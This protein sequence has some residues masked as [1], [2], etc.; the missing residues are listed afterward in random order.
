MLRETLLV[1]MA[2]AV[3]V[4]ATNVDK[5][6]GVE[7]DNTKNVEVSGCKNPPCKFKKG[8]EISM[9]QRFVA[10]R[11]VQDVKNAVHAVIAGVPLPFIGVDG[12]DACNLI[13]NADG[14]PAGC[15]LTKDQEY[16][17]KVSFPILPFYPKVP[18]TVHYELSGNDQNTVACFEVPAKI[19]D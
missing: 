6:N 19:T 12:T 17:F 3:F 8:T 5:C 13:Y 4:N 11:D 10:E 9:E 7:N 2:L 14:S 15:P 1:F 18:L 16:L